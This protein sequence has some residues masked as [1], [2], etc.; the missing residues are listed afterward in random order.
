M[1]ALIAQTA[2][3]AA[4]NVSRAGLA[5]CAPIDATTS[6]SPH[7]D[8]RASP[9][10]RRPEA[11]ATASAATPTSQPLGSRPWSTHSANATA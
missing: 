9:R 8:T 5:P 4:P 11:S 1:P 6:A 2:T 3:P 10:G 7:P